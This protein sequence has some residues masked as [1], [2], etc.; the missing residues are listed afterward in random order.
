[1]F[2]DIPVLFFLLG[3]LFSLFTFPC[4]F[5]L[6]SP[7]AGDTAMVFL[8]DLFLP[9]KAGSSF[10]LFFTYFAGLVALPFRGVGVGF[11]GAHLRLML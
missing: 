8:D 3:F 9:L 2:L 4:I 1:M 5:L 11:G 7:V 6:P 10:H